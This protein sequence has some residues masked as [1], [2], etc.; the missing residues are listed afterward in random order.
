[1][2]VLH[3]A[4]GNLYGGVET[5]LVTLARHR[6]LVPELEQLFALCYDG[7]LNT[8]LVAT[9]AAVHRLPTVRISRPWTIWQGRKVLREL[10]LREHIDMAICH[11]TWPLA[12]FGQAVRT[13]HTPVVFWVHGVPSRNS[14]IE[15]W[16]LW[17]GPTWAIF[18]SKFIQSQMRLEYP[19]VSGTQI[20]YPVELNTGRRDYADTIDIRRELKTPPGAV[21]ILQVSRMEA[22]KGHELHLRALARLPPNINWNCWIV[23][24]AQRPSEA[25]YAQRM[26]R[27]TVELGLA[28]RVH[29]LGERR[30]ILS[31]VRAADIFCQP[32]M[33]PEPFGIVFIEALAAGR[34]VVA[35]A[36][37]GAME[38]VEPTC[39][40]LVP[41]NDVPALAS[42]LQCLLADA[43]LRQSL[44]HEAPRRAKALCDPQS[45]IWQLYQT[46]T[47][48]RQPFDKH[49]V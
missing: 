46:L 14:W 9:A 1:M 45:Q 27:L 22:W 44:G 39:G 35:T 36:L 11:S 23:G 33:G 6:L 31:L 13:T 3:I 26:Q 10:I 19:Q 47:H 16:A 43:P 42:G 41:P 38:I 28:D 49:F 5:L 17:N 24:G 29:F 8:E 40:R 30:D 37:G 18:N 2:K 21:V 25:E 48:V 32:N 15:R 20:Y 34:P 7:R 12:V 4:A